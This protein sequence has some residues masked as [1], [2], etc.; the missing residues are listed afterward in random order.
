MGV[1]SPAGPARLSLLGC[2]LEVPLLFWLEGLGKREGR[3]N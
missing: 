1:G 2:S 3:R